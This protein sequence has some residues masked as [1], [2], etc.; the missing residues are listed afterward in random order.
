MTTIPDPFFVGPPP[1]AIIQFG[2]DHQVVT[3]AGSE[4][5]ARQGALVAY[6]VDLQAL[7]RAAAQKYAATI[8]AGAKP[9]DLPVEQPDRYELVINLKTAKAIG[10]T[11]PSEV[12]ARADKVIR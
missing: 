6:G 10:L 11:I 3:L 1:A 8:L 2:L 7:G 9:A 12:L 5:F 4:T